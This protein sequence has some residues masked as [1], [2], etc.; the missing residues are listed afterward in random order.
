[1]LTWIIALT[2]AVIGLVVWIFLLYRQ[3]KMHGQLR[4]WDKERLNDLNKKTIELLEYDPY[5]DPVIN[6]HRTYVRKDKQPYDS[7]PVFIKGI[8]EMLKEIGELQNSSIN[9]SMPE[10][11]DLR[12]RVTALE[13]NINAA[14]KRLELV[15]RE[16]DRLS[17]EFHGINI[18]ASTIKPIGSDQTSVA[19]YAKHFVPG[20]STTI[21]SNYS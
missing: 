5:N 16:I 21:Y 12:V 11:E 7:A 13:D 17:K 4:K 8:R 2:I 9:C 19:D 6:K 15:E 10:Y 3:N 18:E 20:A 1:M 14:Y